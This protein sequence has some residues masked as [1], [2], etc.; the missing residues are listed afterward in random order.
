MQTFG[1]PKIAPQD[2]KS[3]EQCFQLV[4][5]IMLV[6]MKLTFQNLFEIWGDLRS[7]KVC[8]QKWSRYEIW[9]ISE[10]FINYK[11]KGYKL[12]RLHKLI[13]IWECMKVE[14]A[15]RPDPPTSWALILFQTIHSS[16][17]M[18]LRMSYDDQPQSAKIRG[19]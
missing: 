16:F 11:M 8:F 6:S 1:N 17:I 18:K 15:R 3:I 14:D 4:S 2:W 12:V 13:I 9:L 7:W 5:K 10:T 19:Y